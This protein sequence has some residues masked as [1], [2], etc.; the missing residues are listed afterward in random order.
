MIIKE[1]KPRTTDA[2]NSENAPAKICPVCGAQMYHY[3][4]GGNYK[5]K[6]GCFSV[7][8]AEPVPVGMIRG[9][10]EDYVREYRHGYHD[11]TYPKADGYSD[12][13]RAAVTKILSSW[14]FTRISFVN[15]KTNPH[16]K[17][18]HTV[19]MAVHS[20]PEV[21]VTYRMAP[22]T[23]RIY[24]FDNKYGEVYL[25]TELHERGERKFYRWHNALYAVNKFR[26]TVGIPAP[27]TSKPIAILT[28]GA[29][30]KKKA[31]AEVITAKKKAAYSRV[32]NHKDQIEKFMRN[33]N[34]QNRYIE[35]IK[36]EYKKEFG[37]D[38]P[39]DKL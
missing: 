33:I 28:S 6:E 11:M 3:E 22:N 21:N 17:E 15:P 13:L 2:Y 1:Y 25:Q 16:L 39:A 12:E 30:L 31:E 4:T 26:E 5:K 32:R 27:D 14:G 23:Q 24:V 35:E 36:A 9:D 8:C 29:Q 7:A 19:I 37:E 18:H 10:I 20:S 34:D 38:I